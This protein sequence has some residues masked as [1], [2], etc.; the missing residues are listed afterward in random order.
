MGRRGIRKTSK[1]HYFF[2]WINKVFEVL[3]DRNT[4]K[5]TFFAFGQVQNLLSYFSVSVVFSLFF[6][7][8]LFLISRSHP[9]GSNNLKHLFSSAFFSLFFLFFLFYFTALIL[10]PFKD[11]AFSGPGADLRRSPQL[12]K[13]L[14]IFILYLLL[15]PL[16]QSLTLKCGTRASKSSSK[17]PIS[18]ERP[19]LWLMLYCLHGVNP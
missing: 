19:F 16:Y 7:C 11:Q 17:S 15:L 1:F 10:H 12:G 2:F 13:D 8:G 14:D 5:S 3:L 4:E 9:L 18:F 6:C